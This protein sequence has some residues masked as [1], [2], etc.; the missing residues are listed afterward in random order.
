MVKK[1]RNTGHRRKKSN[2]TINKEKQQNGGAKRSKTKTAVSEVKNRL[3]SAIKAMIDTMNEEYLYS[4]MV[5]AGEQLA[6]N[7][8]GFR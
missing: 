3:V 7:S 4:V 5:Y 8:N 1:K 6:K 2:T